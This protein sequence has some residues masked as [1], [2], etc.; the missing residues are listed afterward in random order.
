MIYIVCLLATAPTC[1]RRKEDL[2]AIW[3]LSKFPIQNIVAS[4]EDGYNS[5]PHMNKLVA[6]DR[7]V[8]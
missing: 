2:L 6:I 5:D 3:F 7:G 8:P 4:E 1:R